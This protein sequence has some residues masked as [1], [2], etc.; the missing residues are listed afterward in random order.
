MCPGVFGGEVRGEARGAPTIFNIQESG[1]GVSRR[2][3]KPVSMRNLRSGIPL[4]R[5]SEVVGACF[6]AGREPVRGELRQERALFERQAAFLLSVYRSGL[7][8]LPYGISMGGP[9]SSDVMS[10]RR[11]CGGATAVGRWTER[12]RIRRGILIPVQLLRSLGGLR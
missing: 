6:L 2:G 7:R 8:G 12:Y 1:R 11:G 5:L 9:I 10:V 4:A 3:A